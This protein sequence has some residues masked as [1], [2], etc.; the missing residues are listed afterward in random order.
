MEIPKNIGTEKSWQEKEWETLSECVEAMSELFHA[1]LRLVGSEPITSGNAEEDLG[2]HPYFREAVV[3][4]VI[5]Y[6]NALLSLDE[7]TDELLRRYK[8]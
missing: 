3:K 2:A 5:G 6:G 7:H 1:Y 8:L 4:K